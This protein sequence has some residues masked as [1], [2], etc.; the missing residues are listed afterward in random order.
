MSEDTKDLLISHFHDMLVSM[1]VRRMEYLTEFTFIETYKDPY[2]VDSF[3]GE[4]YLEI[5]CLCVGVNY[6]DELRLHFS[7]NVTG[8]GLVKNVKILSQED[9]KEN[10]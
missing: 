2:I 5:F 10:E 6:K 3:Y 8:E 9:N 7:C 1:A 4:F